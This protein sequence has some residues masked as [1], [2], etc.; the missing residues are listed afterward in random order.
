MKA[1]NVNYLKIDLHSLK[2]IHRDIKPEN[3][4]LTE[5][6][7]TDI[8]IFDFGLAEYL[9]E[10]SEL[11][12]K[13]SGTPGYVAPEIL[14]DHHYDDRS[15]MFSLGVIL[16]QL[17]SGCTPFFGKNIDEIVIKNTKA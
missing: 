12:F 11:I 15:D 6:N 16:Y 13:R 1:S 3:I 9:V 7:F 2:I 10:G 17:L 14:K 5:P 4:I 8:K